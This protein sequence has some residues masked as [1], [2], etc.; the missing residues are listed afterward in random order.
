MGDESIGAEGGQLVIRTPLLR[1]LQD[2]QKEQTAGFAALKEAMASKADKSDVVRIDGRLE[3]HSRALND[4]TMWKHDREVALTVHQGRDQQWSNKRKAL[5]GAIIA[6][7]T[8]IAMFLGPM[9]ANLA[10]GKP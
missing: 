5:V 4:L 9:L 3:D 2:I 7:L 6:I 8:L 1:V 10:T